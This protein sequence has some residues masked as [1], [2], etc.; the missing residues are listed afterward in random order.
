MEFVEEFSKLSE[1]DRKEV[2][3]IMKLKGDLENEELRKK[4]KRLEG[5]LFDLL[6]EN[7]ELKEEIERKEEENYN[8][9]DLEASMRNVVLQGRIIKAIEFNKKVLDIYTED[10]MEYNNAITNLITLGDEET[11]ERFSEWAEKK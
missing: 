5:T 11:I 10:S 7:K 1:K 2:L 6:L 8:T 9:L 4:I 3:D